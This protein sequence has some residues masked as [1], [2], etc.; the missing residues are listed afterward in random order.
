MIPSESLPPPGYA[1][2]VGPVPGWKLQKNVI[3][4]AKTPH[5]RRVVRDGSASS[6]MMHS[7]T[8]SNSRSDL[9]D[10]QRIK[11][12]ESATKAHMLDGLRCILVLKG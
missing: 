4:Q 8:D 6:R 1:S 5:S 11:S 2:P 7:P 10:Q 9:I 3:A 12:A